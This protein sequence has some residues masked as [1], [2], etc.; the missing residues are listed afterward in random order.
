MKIPFKTS[1]KLALQGKW[2]TRVITIILSAFSFALFTLASMAYTYNQFD[3][4]VRGYQ[5]YLKNTNPYVVFYN[6]KNE[7]D[8]AIGEE[9]ISYIEN[10]LP[11]RFIHEYK[12]FPVSIA[13]FLPSSDIAFSFGRDSDVICATENI[14]EKFG[15]ELLAGRYPVA[16]D[17][18]A[19]SEA[20][21][22]IFLEYGYS[23]NRINFEY[24]A[25][26]NSW[27]YN[28]NLPRAETEI[29]NAPQ[30]LI[31]KKLMRENALSDA[32]K[33]Y[34]EV[35]IVGVVDTHNTAASDETTF[36]KPYGRIFCSQ[37]WR[38]SDDRIENEYCRFLFAIGDTDYSSVRKIVEVG[39]HFFG[40]CERYV[41]AVPEI[42]LW[43]LRGLIS[44][45]G[46][47]LFTILLSCAGIVFGIFAVVLNIH[48]ISMSAQLKQR[49]VGILRSMGAGKRDIARL[50]MVEALLI[51]VCSFFL[52]LIT[53][54]GL[55][56]GIIKSLTYNHTFGVS[57][58]IFNGWNVLLLAGMSF[59]V[60]V[61]AALIPIH[62]FFKQTIVD[63]LSG[64]YKKKTK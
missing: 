41:E 18:I 31:G 60:P 13:A 12:N 21:F 55:Y 47:R 3:Y 20:Q 35:T 2:I 45:S 19:V 17:E 61:L 7:Y 4:I 43:K 52:A 63:N 42:G 49:K 9:N 5:Y 36:D 11:H 10:Q 37:M 50:F 58:Y 15:Y 22:K 23:D 29:I 24:R 27:Y 62:N 46:E 25:N 39:L 38:D 53:D 57:T 56:Y 26:D 48:L 44:D 32:A 64:N 6:Y 16:V 14:Y 34:E 33:E 8:G 30:D 51:G 40:D 1:C 28:N 54:L 59:I